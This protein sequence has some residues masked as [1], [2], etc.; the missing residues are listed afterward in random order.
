M[1]CSTLIYA[2]EMAPLFKTVQHDLPALKGIQ[3]QELETLQQQTHQPFEPDPKRE[4][5]MRKPILVLHSSG[6]TGSLPP[7]VT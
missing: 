6:S 3:I 1:Q 5:T 7:V 4:D 2:K